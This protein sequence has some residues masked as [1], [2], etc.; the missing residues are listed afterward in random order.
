V[1]ISVKVGFDG[2]ANKSMDWRRLVEVDA[3]LVLLDL[4]E[5]DCPLLSLGLLGLAE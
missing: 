1:S 5:V 4:A 3:S 2:E